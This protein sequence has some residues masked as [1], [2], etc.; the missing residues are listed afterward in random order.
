MSRWSLAGPD[1][2]FMNYAA[3]ANV[4]GKLMIVMGASMVLPMI[5]SLYYQ[6]DDLYAII[7]SGAVAAGFGLVLWRAFRNFH[8]INLKDSFLIA[9]FG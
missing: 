9:V 7:F 5:C 6:E 4:L 8:N 2:D 3:I 1:F